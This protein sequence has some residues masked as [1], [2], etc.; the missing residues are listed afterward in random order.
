MIRFHAL[1]LAL[2]VGV[3]SG[4]ADNR[5]PV[6]PWDNAG[7]IPAPPT[8]PTPPAPPAPPMYGHHHRGHGSGGHGVSVS[9]HDGRV[10]IEGV[11]EMFEQQMRM[12]QQQI[13]HANLPPHIRA[14]VQKRLDQMR[15]KLQKR[16]RHV[17]VRDLERLGEELGQMG[18]E[19]GRDLGDVAQYYHFAVPAVPAMPRQPPQPP[20]PPHANTRAGGNSNDDDNDADDND[21]DDANDDADI[22]DAARDLGDL[23]LAPG[24]RD[25]L[26]RLHGDAERQI[27]AARRELARA[28][29][30]LH[31]QIAD[32][33]ASDA[34]IARAID[35]VSAQEAAIRKAEILHWVDA[36]RVL[37]DGQRR[38]LDKASKHH[39]K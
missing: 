4:H 26:T 20:Q 14:R 25:A 30:N 2:V 28:E 27:T 17:D 39:T 19:L 37:D 29:A 31:A 18:E 21:A 7:A 5:R 15:V 9:V 10:Q 38:R 23:S 6:D 3:A 32:L 33:A 16:L 11:A 35:A 13:D 34:E 36:R 8:P 1:A 24:Q 22:D 12:A